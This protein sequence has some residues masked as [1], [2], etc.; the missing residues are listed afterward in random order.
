MSDGWIVVIVVGVATL[1]LKAAGPV[2][3][4]RRQLPRRVDAVVALIA[5][6][7]LTSLV[8]VQTFGGDEE[9]VVD[10]RVPG[11]AAAALAIWRGA[12]VIP[13]M[14]IAAVVTALLRLVA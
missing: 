11:V 5:P 10:A 1:C 2:I 3:L 6:V 8:V 9:I 14:A 13:A 12:S 4:G 7:M